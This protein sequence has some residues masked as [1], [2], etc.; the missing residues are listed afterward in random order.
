MRTAFRTS[1][2]FTTFISTLLLLAFAFTPAGYAH[3]LGA[4]ADLVKELKPAVVNISTTSIRHGTPSPFGNREAPFDEFFKRFFDNMPEREFKQKG[5]GTG[6]IISNDG[7]IVTNNH[8]IER[9]NDIDVVLED[10]EKYA[11]KI[12]GRDPKTDVA[13]LKIKPDKPLP[14]VKFGDSNKLRIGDWVIAI[15][16]PFGLG[17][18]VTTG[19][20]SAKGRSLGLGAYDDFIQTDAAINPG[21][22]GG[23]L[24]NLEGQVVG[25]NS[26]IVAGGQGIGFA[27]PIDMIKR[28]VEQLKANGKVVRGWLGV[29]VQHIT[30]DIAES[31]G[32]QGQEGALVSDVTPG[33]P[34]DKAGIKRGDVIVE[35]NGHK[36]KEMQDLP[37][38][39]A[40]YPPN[41][42]ADVKVRR[43]KRTK[44]LRVKIGEM[45]GELAQ[46]SSSG[47]GNERALGLIVQEI[48]PSIQ[49]RFG[50]EGGHGVVITGV[51]PGSV[52]AESGLRPGDIVVEINRIS[53]GS[54]EDYRRVV[55]SLKPK[56]SAL[57]LIKRGHNTIYVALKIDEPNK[58]G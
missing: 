44:N 32:L 35:F 47:R 15:G 43:G 13:L 22:S 20:V 41:K 46:T 58:K 54:L 29:L 36:I 1:T 8:V 48:T 19:I 25:M 6:F 18:T 53:I 9:A 10:G 52:A 42:V 40:I 23:P 31:L 2:L 37:R 50:I 33:G 57:F 39:V 55:A 30:P 38:A 34:A 49:R 45:P 28:I 51:A 11:A 24:F 5:L 27:I 7:Y 14:A 16:N 4:L 26:A 3:D 56:K 12:I 21:N 17:H